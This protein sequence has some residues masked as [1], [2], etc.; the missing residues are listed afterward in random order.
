MT[1]LQI[2]C[3]MFAAG[4]A[5]GVLFTVLT[6]LRLPYPRWFGA[7]HGLLGLAAVGVLAYAV[8]RGAEPVPQHATWALAVLTA[9]M[10]G[11]VT[12]FRV[13]KPRH[14]RVWLAMGHGSL[15]LVGLYL[16]Y[17]AAF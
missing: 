12:L 6:A 10:L 11:G 1:L 15:A 14:G 5:G 16:L 17:S 9:A 8:F 3:L 7:G 2:A 4:A 13:I